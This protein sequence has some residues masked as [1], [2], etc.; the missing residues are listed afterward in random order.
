MSESIYV[1]SIGALRSFR[2]A[3][4]SF[5]QSARESLDAVSREISKAFSWL[6][7]RCDYWRGQVRLCQDK[8]REA[9]SAL[10]Y[11]RNS[12]DGDTEPDCSHEERKLEEARARLRHIEGELATAERETQHLRDAVTQYDAFSHRLRHALEE[13]VPAAQARL[14]GLVGALDRYVF[15]PVPHAG[16]DGRVD[17]ADV[18]IRLRRNWKHIKKHVGRPKRI[19]PQVDRSWFKDEETLKRVTA[20]VISEKSAT[21]R[22]WAKDA[23]SGDT[24]V[25]EYHAPDKTQIGAGC[26]AGGS[27]M[28]LC[29]ARVVV[30]RDAGDWH[31]DT[32]YPVHDLF[33]VW[34]EATRQ[35]V[36]AAP[37]IVADQPGERLP[38]DQRGKPRDPR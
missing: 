14:V 31:V 24:L 25:L 3:L 4:F 35:L 22:E 34:G 28:P 19:N 6:A 16:V 10:S 17:D 1:Q 5:D 13:E 33:G 36:N 38:L 21:I 11:C 29:D 7:D 12:G 8:V 20:H 2:L 26:Y 32:V 30:G 18:G 23:K 15:T 9:E 37:N 27:P